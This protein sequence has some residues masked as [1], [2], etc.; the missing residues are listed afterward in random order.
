MEELQK[1][2][3]EQEK[4][5]DRTRE[6]AQRLN[7]VKQPR[8]RGGLNFGAGGGDLETI[9][10]ARSRAGLLAGHGQGID[11]PRPL[12]RDGRAGGGARP[13]LLFNKHGLAAALAQN[14][15]EFLRCEQVLAGGRGNKPNLQAAHGELSRAVLDFLRPR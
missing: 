3:R 1:L 11:R 7:R 12:E 4:L 15:R 5:L 6:L 2:A 14:A 9:R 10:L 8:R 13:S